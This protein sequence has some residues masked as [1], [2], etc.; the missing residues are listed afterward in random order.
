MRLI[1]A[2]LLF[3]L[4]LVLVAPATVA[5]S[6]PPSR[7]K[8]ESRARPAAFGVTGPAPAATAT[9]LAPVAAPTQSAG[10]SPTPDATGTDTYGTYVAGLIIWGVIIV[11]VAVTAFLVWRTRPRR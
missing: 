10:L 6:A 4:L 8:L 9:V 7:L 3:A 1:R 11:L 2:A 5:A